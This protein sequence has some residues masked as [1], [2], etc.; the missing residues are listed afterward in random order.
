MP[1]SA[2]VAAAKGGDT[3]VDQTINFNQPVKTP[4]EVGRMMRRYATY[5]LAGARR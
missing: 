1:A 2:S 4:Y 3:V 5:G